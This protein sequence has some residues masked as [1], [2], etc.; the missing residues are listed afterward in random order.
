MTTHHLDGAGDHDSSAIGDTRNNTAD[1]P[2][3]SDTCPQ[4]TMDTPIF[5]AVSQALGTTQSMSTAITGS[6]VMRLSE[7]PVA[8]RGFDT[9][10]NAPDSDWAEHRYGRPSR[11]SP[12]VDPDSPEGAAILSLFSRIKEDEEG[13]GNWNGGD[14]VDAVTG[15]FLELGID[16]DQ[17]PTDA[18][19]ALRNALGGLP[20]RGP[21]S[22]VY[23]VRIST[24]HD[25]SEG[26]VRTAL[27]VLTHQLGPGTS[28]ELVSYD[29]DLLARIEHQPRP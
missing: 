10:T 23:G 26:L 21:S 27:H 9:S 19:A 24:D 28:V 5:D 7:D 25:E 22:T 2:T 12:K 3:G 15:W 6:S 17:D 29:R 14:V 8:S 4:A 13:D 16:P 1:T 11:S 18:R 20:G